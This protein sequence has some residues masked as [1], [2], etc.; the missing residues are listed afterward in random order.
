MDTGGSWWLLG[1]QVCGDLI[2]AFVQA[3][4]V[5]WKHLSSTCKLQSLGGH[6]V[7]GELR[8]MRNKLQALINKLATRQC[9]R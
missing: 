1:F 2:K 4:V 5:E 3:T 9:S 6:G 7:S 8:S